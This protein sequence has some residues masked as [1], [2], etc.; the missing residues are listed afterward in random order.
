MWNEEE[1]PDQWKESTI[2]PIYKKGDKTDWE[3]VVEC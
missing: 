2:E 3:I 1:L